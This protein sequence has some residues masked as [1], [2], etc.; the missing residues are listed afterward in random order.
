[1][2]VPLALGGSLMLGLFALVEGRIARDPLIPL[3]VF[4]MPAL[5]AANLIV[6]L[7][8]AGDLRMWY[9]VSL[10][11]QQVHGDDALERRGRLPADDAEHRRRLGDGAAA[12]RPL[13]RAARR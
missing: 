1:M 3:D 4:Q 13:R 12:G 9:F 10:Y 8:F 5:R 6:A 11:L 7:L 2:L